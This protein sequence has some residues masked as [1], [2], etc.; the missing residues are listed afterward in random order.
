MWIQLWSCSLVDMDWQHSLPPSP[1]PRD[2]LS[3][4]NSFSLS[5]ISSYKRGKTW[6]GPKLNPVA[7]SVLW[8]LCKW[9]SN[10]LTIYPKYCSLRPWCQMKEPRLSVNVHAVNLCA[11]NHIY[12]LQDWCW[13]KQDVQAPS[14]SCCSGSSSVFAP[15]HMSVNLLQVPL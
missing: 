7:S 5:W 11:L 13:T 8:G 10:F 3:L 9:M 15:Q 6:S 2:K 14:H 4:A 1:H 12:Q